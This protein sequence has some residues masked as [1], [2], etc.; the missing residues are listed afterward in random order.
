MVLH[1]SFLEGSGEEWKYSS[2]A[3]LVYMYRGLA[4]CL[5]VTFCVSSA[6][7]ASQKFGGIQVNFEYELNSAGATGGNSG[8]NA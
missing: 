7:A 1:T 5:L 3:S 6:M 4:R 2:I 8:T